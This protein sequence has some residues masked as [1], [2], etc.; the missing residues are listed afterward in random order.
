MTSC[1]I[2]RL[3][4]L[5][6]PRRLLAAIDDIFF[7]ASSKTSF[8]DEAERAAFRER[9]LGQFLRED[10]EWVYVVGRD[11][12]THGTPDVVGYLVA[13]LDDPARSHRFADISYFR[14]FAQVTPQYPAQLHIN[15]REGARG[16]GLGSR[17]L[18]RALVDVSAAGVPGV[19]VV[20]GRDMRNVTFYNRNGFEEVAV[21]EH[22]GHEVVLLG[23]SF[24][25]T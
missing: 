7:A 3:D 8:A 9:W 11:L 19:H 6:A 18:Q 25:A 16:S 17:L 5:P 14:D 12:E 15:L 23:R 1:D 13:S 20:T 2:R 4:Q 10:P 21:A 24:R 22:G